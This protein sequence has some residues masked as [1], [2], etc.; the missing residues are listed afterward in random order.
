MCFYQEQQSGSRQSCVIVL[1]S[2]F[3]L[4]KIYKTCEVILSRFSFILMA[5]S[6]HPV[7]EV[8]A[9]LKGLEQGLCVCDYS[10]V[11][12][13]RRLQKKIIK[14]RLSSTMGRKQSV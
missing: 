1:Y 6:Y 10:K 14:F 5:S 11:E 9:L 13:F 4:T 7:A 2:T 3:E 8:F 12:V